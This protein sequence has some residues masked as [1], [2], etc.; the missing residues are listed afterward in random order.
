MEKKIPKKKHP[1]YTTWN[2][3]IAR[4][5]YKSHT[6]YKYYGAK[7]VTVDDRWHEFWNFVEDV[8]NHLENGHLLYETG[9]HLDKDVKGGKIYS[10]ETCVVL[11]KEENEKISRGKN[12]R[13]V[14]AFNNDETI[15]FESM[16]NASQILKVARTSIESCVKRGNC[17]KSGYYFKYAD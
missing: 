11:S 8:D 15:E 16:I 5:Y 2:G 4:C 10:L 1:L 3:M 12:K 17:H 6:H 9:Y 13:K 7:G 14:V